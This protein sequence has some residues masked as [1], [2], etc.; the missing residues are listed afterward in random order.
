M[1]EDKIKF[2]RCIVYNFTLYFLKYRSEQPPGSPKESPIPL[3]SAPAYAS[4]SRT[5]LFV[6][7]R[8]ISSLV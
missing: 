6:S 5:S 8:P 7:E 3:P 1:I 2:P 4:S